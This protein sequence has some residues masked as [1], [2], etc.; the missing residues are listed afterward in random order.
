MANSVIKDPGDTEEF[1]I[2]WRGSD[3]TLDYVLDD[4]ETVTASTW[5]LPAPL[6]EVS[7]G[8]TNTTSYVF[9]SGGV[10][11]TRYDMECEITTSAGRTIN[12][13]LQLLVKELYV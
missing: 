1:T 6:V 5:T 12:R 11:G 4:T 7:S 9:V 8:F 2:V 3:A 10:D 13:T